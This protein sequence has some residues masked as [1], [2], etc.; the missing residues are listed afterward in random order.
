MNAISLK[1]AIPKGPQLFV[2][3]IC[4]LP[5]YH[6]CSDQTTNTPSPIS[7][8][9]LNA[10]GDSLTFLGDY[11]NALLCFQQSMDLARAEADSFQYYDSRLDFACV[12]ERIKEPEKA[13]AY[14]EEV[15]QAYMRAGDT[16]RI[17]RAYS[18]IA[19]FYSFSGNQEK[20]IETAQKGFNLL[21]IHGSDIERCAAYNQMAFTYSDMGNWAQARPLLDT[22]LLLM[23]KSGV[24]EQLPGIQLNLGNCH[25]ELGNFREARQLLNASIAGADSL[26]YKHIRS[27]AIERLSQIEEA[28]GNYQNALFLFKKSKTLRDSV[29]NEE[30]NKRIQQLEVQY[31]LREQAQALQISEAERKLEISRR[32]LLLLLWFVSLFIGGLWIYKRQR[33][34]VRY[35]KMLARNRE[36]LREFTNLLIKKNSHLLSLEQQLQGITAAEADGVEPEEESPEIPT[37]LYNAV[38]LTEADWAAFKSAFERSYPGYILK[39]RNAF[40]E[41]S[42]AEE[43]LFL[44]LK[45]NL[46]R[47]EIAATL[48]ISP[49]TVKKGR[50]R[51]RKRLSLETEEDLNQFIQQF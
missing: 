11:E 43:R 12:H 13:I 33:K 47:Q 22:A 25:R 39:L 29:L 9:R 31:Q 44:L 1:L 14:G 41:I 50:L 51:L 42:N 38:I 19:S 49:S 46:T 32:N 27:R 23:L 21:K 17:G 10:Q 35:R 6:A 20:F 18:T 28:E 36:Q 37:N 8:A 5:V 48:G 15:L 34:L 26:G 40:P 7:A 45:L 16:T 4:S 30:K 2:I 3:L 24:L